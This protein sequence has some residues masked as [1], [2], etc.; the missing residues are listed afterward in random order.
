MM[1]AASLKLDFV[2][3]IARKDER[4]F[5]DLTRDPVR[6]L[7]QSG[8]DLSPGEIFGVVDVIKNTTASPLAHA[9]S[10]KKQVWQS[11]V[12]DKTLK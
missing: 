1:T 7:L 4:F 2:L 9:L 12:T 11:I 6:T 8:I 5:N 10:A 3:K